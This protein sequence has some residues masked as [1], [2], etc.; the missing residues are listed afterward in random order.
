M[1]RITAALGTLVLS[2]FATLSAVGADVVQHLQGANVTG[3]LV[4]QV[5][6]DELTLTALGDRFHVRLLLPDAESAAKAQAKIERAGLAGR[7]TAAAWDG[8]CLP[9]ADDLPA[10]PVFD[11]MSTADGRLLIPMVNGEVSCWALRQP[12]EEKP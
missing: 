12:E 4:A 8:E 1:T 10:C 6:S 3:G 11:A 2:A 9:F 7:F 5:G